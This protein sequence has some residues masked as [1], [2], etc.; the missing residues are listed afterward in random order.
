[1]R[2]CPGSAIALFPTGR[3]SLRLSAAA[4][5]EPEDQDFWK[6]WGR[7]GGFQDY[8]RP[9]A[10]KGKCGVCEFNVICGGCRSLS[11]SQETMGQEP[12]CL[13]EPKRKGNICL[14]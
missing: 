1:M 14:I 13:Y 2:G 9:A 8:Q 3:F 5:R 6:I 11:A 7:L 10:L 12:Y 4:S